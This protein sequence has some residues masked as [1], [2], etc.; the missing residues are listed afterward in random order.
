VISGDTVS[1]QL[2]LNNNNYDGYLRNALEPIIQ[3]GIP[4]V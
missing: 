4:Y 3:S 1:P 2:L